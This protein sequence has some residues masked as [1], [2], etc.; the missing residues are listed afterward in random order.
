MIPSGARRLLLSALLL[1]VGWLPDI[2]TDLAL[3]SLPYRLDP[4]SVAT[5]YR[6]LPGFTAPGTPQKLDR[7]FYLRYFSKTPTRTVLLPVPLRYRDA[8]ARLEDPE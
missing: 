6:S 4:R 3:P 5:E 1:L 7:S 8:A 2:R